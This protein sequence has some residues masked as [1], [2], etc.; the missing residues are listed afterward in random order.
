[1]KRLKKSDSED[2]KNYRK[3]KKYWRTLLKKNSNL[4]CFS[5][6]QYPLFQQKYLTESDVVDYLMTINKPYKRCY[7][8]YQELMDYFDSRDYR[9]FFNCIHHLES[10]LPE[11]DYCH[12]FV[13]LGGADVF[14]DFFKQL[15][16]VSFCNQ[17]D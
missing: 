6:K 1:M 2:M 5:L 9:A 3:L 4:N 12:T 8:I 15:N 14:L 16:L 17:S 11:D 10:S 13:P 7:E